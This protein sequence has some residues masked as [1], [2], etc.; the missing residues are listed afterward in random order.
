MYKIALQY[1]QLT[2][3]FETD[4]EDPFVA[5]AAGRDKAGEVALTLNQLPEYRRL[6]ATDFTVR[7]T[8]NNPQIE[9]FPELAQHHFGQAELA[10]V[11]KEP[12]L[13]TMK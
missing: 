10:Y 7:V 6:H 1:K 9:L 5:L 2:L 8:Y 13:R 4:D 3:A 12:T 11:P